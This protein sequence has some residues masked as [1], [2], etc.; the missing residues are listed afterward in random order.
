MTDVAQ[1]LARWHGTPLD[2]RNAGCFLERRTHLLTVAPTQRLVAVAY[3]DQAQRNEIAVGQNVELKFDHLPTDIF[4]SAV[5]ENFAART[6]ITPRLIS[7]INTAANWRPSAIT[8]A[9][10]RLS[11][12]A[13]PATVP[14]PWR[15]QTISRRDARP[16]AHRAGT[17]F[18]SR[19]DLAKDPA[20][21]QIPNV[22]DGHHGPAGNGGTSSVGCSDGSGGIGNLSFLSDRL[23]I[24]RREWLDNFADRVFLQPPW[25]RRDHPLPKL[26]TPVH[27]KHRVRAGSADC[28]AAVPGV[29]ISMGIGSVLIVGNPSRIRML[30]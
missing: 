3:V 22:A 12:P 20:N 16:G 23:G 6:G 15:C 8:K 26:T 9:A 19:V 2:P 21:F 11:S 14:A 1:P 24:V 17:S 13:Y 10:S 27:P 25:F 18:R 4:D 28:P 5:S 30:L 7:R 29:G